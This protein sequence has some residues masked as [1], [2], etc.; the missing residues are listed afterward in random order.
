M[1][2]LDLAIRGGAIISAADIGC[3]DIG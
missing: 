1:S 2:D 3:C